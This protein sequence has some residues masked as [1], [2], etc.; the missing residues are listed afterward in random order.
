MREGAYLFKRLAFHTFHLMENGV[1]EQFLKCELCFKLTFLFKYKQQT[2]M[3][4]KTYLNIFKS[5]N[6]M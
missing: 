2:L 3:L 4:S 1:T 5:N 6:V